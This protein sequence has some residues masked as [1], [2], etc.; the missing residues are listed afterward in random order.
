MS[1]LGLNTILGVVL[2]WVYF[3]VELMALVVIFAA[4]V[5]FAVGATLGIWCH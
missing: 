5:T 1:L 2:A 4:I 3:K